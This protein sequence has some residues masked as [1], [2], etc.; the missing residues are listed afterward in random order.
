[1]PLLRARRPTFH[2]VHVWW[3][4][5]CVRGGR[6]ADH[7]C[8]KRKRLSKNI[9]ISCFLY[10]THTPANVTHRAIRTSSSSSWCISRVVREIFTNNRHDG[11]DGHCYIKRVHNN[12]NDNI[13]RYVVYIYALLVICHAVLNFERIRINE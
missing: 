12:N 7:E 9:M 11:G 8:N 13:H 2:Y 6:C 10:V 4:Y 1:M 5:M 3:A